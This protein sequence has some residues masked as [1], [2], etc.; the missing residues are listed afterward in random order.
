MKL[1]SLLALQLFALMLVS[2]P[3]FAVERVA[4]VIGNDSYAHLPVLNNATRDARAIARALE[5]L[6]FEVSLE[7]NASKREI[8]RALS[9]FES[10]LS[11]TGATGLVYFAGHGI[12]ADG[13]NYLIPIDAQVIDEDDLEPE[14]IEAARFLEGMALAGNPLNILI[15]DACRDNPLPRRTRSSSR[16]L[17]VTSIPSGAKGTAIIYA[18]GEG[19]V[20]QDG[21]RGGHGVF[22]QALLNA[23]KA[24]NQTLE[25]VIK[26]VTRDVLERTNGR[27]RPW[28]LASIQGEFVFNPAA[29]PAAPYATQPPPAPSGGASDA[30]HRIAVAREIWEVVKNSN[31]PEMVRRFRDEFHDTPYAIAADS[32]LVK[33]TAPKAAPKPKPV[34]KAAP[35]PAPKAAPPPTVATK[36]VPKAITPP[37]PKPTPAPPV[38]APKPVTES[39]PAEKE[40]GFFSSITESLLG[41]DDN[42]SSSEEPTPWTPSK[43]TDP[44]DFTNERSADH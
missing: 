27:Q 4:L 44:S 35:K 10:R 43:T 14:A 21:P 28:S 23:M 11:S 29:S 36:P 33:L 1:K 13:R 37:A 7:V 25:E 24:P 38:E 2:L 34:P 8:Y 31:D 5:E 16:G 26:S 9:S 30:P 39:P 32:L 42:A 3:L 15:L 18:A 22:T 12:Q 20:S 6:D 17:G 40:K 41:D 19:Q